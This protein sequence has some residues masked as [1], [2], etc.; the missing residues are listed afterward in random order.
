M[1]MAAITSKGQVTLP[2]KVREVLR[3]GPGDRID[4]VVDPD[5]SVTVR[6]GRSDIADLK[7]M[8]HRRRG[9]PVSLSA[10]DDAILREHRKRR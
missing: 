1:P 3:V 4:F 8:L 5:G 9:R 10:M 6:A 2:R 7:G